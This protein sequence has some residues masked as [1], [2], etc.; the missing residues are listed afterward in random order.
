MIEYLFLRKQDFKMKSIFEYN[1]EQLFLYEFNLKYSFATKTRR[2][3]CPM[4]ARRLLCPQGTQ[5]KQIA[6]ATLFSN[7][8]LK[9]FWQI[10]QNSNKL[11]FQNA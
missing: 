8:V 10:L 4:G 1:S 3:K 11:L 6:N 7:L 5:R 9:L 2:L